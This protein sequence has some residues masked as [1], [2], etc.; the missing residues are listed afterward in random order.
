METTVFSV[1]SVSCSTCAGKIEKEIKSMDGVENVVVDL[2]T[3]SVK[4]DYSP[5]NIQPNDIKKKVKVLGYE[6]TD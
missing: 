4:F 6:V 3:Q 5:T 1:P 2:K